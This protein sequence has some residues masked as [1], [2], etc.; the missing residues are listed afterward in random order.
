MT[1]KTTQVERATEISFEEAYDEIRVLRDMQR[2][3]SG[4]IEV[5]S[6]EHPAY[7][8]IYIVIPSTSVAF[9]LK[10]FAIQDF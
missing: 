7:G 9:L 8:S 6:G 3:E 4:G 1:I 2:R 5:Y 10:P